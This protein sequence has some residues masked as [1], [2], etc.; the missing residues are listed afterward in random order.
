MLERRLAMKPLGRFAQIAHDHLREHRPRMYRELK[1]EGRLREFV[2][3]Q[4]EQYGQMV[5]DLVGQG[6]AHDA[7]HEEA[8]LLYLYLPTEEDVPR[9]GENPRPYL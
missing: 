1:K 8:A 7:A 4:A 3:G 2:E 6:V 5:A 9:L